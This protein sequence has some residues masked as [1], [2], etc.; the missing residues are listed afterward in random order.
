M[1]DDRYVVLVC[2]GRKFTDA[3]TVDRWLSMLRTRPTLVVHGGAG[4]A[5]TLAHMWAKLNGVEARPYPADWTKLGPRA[6]PV[7]NQQM[8]D[9]EKPDLVLAFEGGRG[10][11]DMVRRARA[12]GVPV[13][14]AST[15]ATPEGK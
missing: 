12:A 15:A 8:L 14:E 10:T 6:G 1:S 9:A 3:D 7:R 2:G 13:I 11:A 4:G 5:D